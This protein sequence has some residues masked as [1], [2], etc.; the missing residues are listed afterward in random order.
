MTMVWPSVLPAS[1]ATVRARMSDVPPAEC[2]TTSVMGLVGKVCA[3]AA[4]S[5]GVK[6]AASATR[7]SNR[8]WLI[9]VSSFVIECGALAGA[10]SCPCGMGPAQ[11]D[12]SCSLLGWR[13]SMDHFSKAAER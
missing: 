11:S 4:G 2:G 7:A 9:E 13:F 1:A 6:Q 3:C 10:P 12:P 5:T 8:L